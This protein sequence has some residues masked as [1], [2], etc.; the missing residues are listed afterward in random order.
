MLVHSVIGFTTFTTTCNLQ[1]AALT[2]GLPKNS[3]TESLYA[4]NVELLE[5]LEIEKKK[6]E[7]HNTHHDVIVSRL[8]QLVAAVS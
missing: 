2:E 4:V 1:G 7:E 3:V 6:V 5:R 8:E